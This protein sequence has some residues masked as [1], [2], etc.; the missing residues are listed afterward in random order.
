M[1]SKNI[2]LIDPI[3]SQSAY[4]EET[5]KLG[6]KPYALFT[7]IFNKLPDSLVKD[8][9][10]D[11]YEEIFF[12]NSM[13]ETIPKLEKLK[14][15][16]VIPCSQLALGVSDFIAKNLNL[17]GN[18]TE[19]FKYRINKAFMRERLRS[20]N[21]E[22]IKYILTD[23]IDE[24]LDWVKSTKYP[25]ILKP[26]ELTGGSV[27]VKKCF[28]NDDVIMAF[29][30]ILSMKGVFF[31]NI[32]GK[33][34]AEEYLD[35]KE[36]IV[37][38][39]NNHNERHLIAIAG[40]DKLQVNGNASI[41]KNV[42]SIDLNSELAINISNYAIYVSEAFDIT[43]GIND[44]E[45]KI[46]PNG[47]RLVELNNRLSG[48]KIPYSIEKCCGFNSYQENIRL[49][50]GE[51]L[52]NNNIKYSRNY[53]ICFLS[54][55]SPGNIRKITGLETIKKLNSYDYHEVSTEVGQ[56]FPET[57]DLFTS[58]GMVILINEDIDQLKSD[59]ETVHREMEL[60]TG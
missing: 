41:Y 38:I 56:Y 15:N 60:K 49:F 58:W 37:N 30:D 26:P 10:F 40:V 17:I 52:S 7:K 24:I 2:L 23:K 57:K 21:I 50:S 4:L 11:K 53:N 59:T 1:I 54:N 5:I 14:L 55:K 33:V 13:E 45:V 3:S 39:S 28:N 12:F 46:T 43:V 35:G 19:S 51:N 29:N 27:L 34:L 9:D 25:V 22:N 31:Q 8:I 20:K 32:E 42:Y 18:P 16:S 44:I 48:A 36:Y 6:Y 47:I